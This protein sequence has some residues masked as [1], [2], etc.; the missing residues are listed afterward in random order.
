MSSVKVV[1]KAL[2]ASSYDNERIFAVTEQWLGNFPQEL[3]LFK[4]FVKS[5]NIHT[6]YLVI[7]PEEVLT[8]GGQAVR[9]EIFEREGAKLAIEATSAALTAG[10]VAPSQCGAICFVSCTMPVIPSIDAVV[11][12]HLGLNR[13]IHRIPVY[14]WGC[15][16][17]V[18]GLTLAEKFTAASN[19]H[20]LLV[21]TELCSL[22]FHRKDLSAGQLV[23][24]AIFGDGAAAVVISPENKGLCF[25]DSQSYLLPETRHIMGYDLFDD[26]AHLRLDKE[27]PSVLTAHAPVVVDAFL[28][29]HGLSR[30]DISH[31]LFHPGG[32]KILDALETLFCS[33]DSSGHYA[34]QVLERYGNLS[35]STVLF[36]LAEFF[37]EGNYQPGQKALMLGVGPGLTIEI[38]LF[39]YR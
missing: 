21:S 22:V 33:K 24:S 31:W 8:I 35:S 37:A 27:L 16:G 29:Q 39:E 30:N 11:V 9:A 18:L 2:P 20:S 32:T 28:E 17:G 4:R 6:R 34:R 15:A 10:G 36:V 25:V 38:I 19:S 12:D 5:S 13:T 14:Q 26:G 3:A 1:S 23:G 7:P